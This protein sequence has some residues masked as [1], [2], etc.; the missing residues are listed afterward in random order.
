MVRIALLPAL[1]VSITAQVDRSPKRRL[2][3]SRTSFV[4]K[5]P[6]FWDIREFACAWRSILPNTTATLSA[7]LP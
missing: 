4:G 5:R 1:G 6:R 2:D 3:Q 7:K